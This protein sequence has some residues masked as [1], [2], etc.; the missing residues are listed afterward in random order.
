[1]NSQTSLTAAKSSGPHRHLTRS[2]CVML[3]SR[4]H[5]KTCV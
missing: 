3:E 2:F 4:K 1:M 5:G